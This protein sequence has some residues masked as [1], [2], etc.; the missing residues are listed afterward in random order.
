[1]RRN[2]DNC[3]KEYEADERNLRRGWGLCCS[4][5][6]AA[7]KREKSRPDYDPVKVT[8]NNFRRANWNNPDF[9]PESVKID[10]NYLRFGQSA[11]N[12]IGGS[13]IISGIT[14]E[15]YRIMDGVAYDEWDA[16]VY[17]VGIGEY[18]EGDDEYW[19]HKDFD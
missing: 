11:P 5:S 6:C 10:K 18:D 13:G 16:P 17:D 2:C 12:I 19:G 4:K 8:E 15:G 3:G 7:K 1:M 9:M 14:S